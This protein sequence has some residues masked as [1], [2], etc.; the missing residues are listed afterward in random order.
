MRVPL[1]MEK[2]EC[3]QDNSVR[4]N[5]RLSSPLFKKRATTSR[6]QA[7]HSS[8]I[9]ELLASRPG[10]VFSR[11]KILDSLWGDKKTVTD[12]SVD[13]HI[14]LLRDKLGP[15]GRHMAN[16]RGVGYKLQE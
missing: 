3:L 14:K 15:A 2:P 4:A 16:I 11:E 8:K 1:S 13:V 7:S 9:I 5:S 10:W 12:R 6:L